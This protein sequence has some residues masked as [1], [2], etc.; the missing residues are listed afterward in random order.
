MK[1]YIL[2]P[3]TLFS[4]ILFLNFNNVD[5]IGSANEPASSEFS[6]PADVEEIIDNSCYGC[7]NSDSKNIRGKGKL[8]F[9]ELGELS[10]FKLVGKL[11]K[12]SKEIKKDNMPPKKFRK[13]NPESVLTTEQKEIMINWAESTAKSYTE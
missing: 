11:D 13:N 6:M 4:A 9:D 12:I 1:K 7:H 2:I 3:I 5:E 8:K 10:T